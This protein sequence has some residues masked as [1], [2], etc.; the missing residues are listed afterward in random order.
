MPPPR[1]K[2][3]VEGAAGGDTLFFVQGWPDDPTLWDELVDALS[4]RYRCVRVVLPNYEGG[5]YRRW[6]YSHDDIVE[7]LA[8]CIR[9]FAAAKP[10]TLVAHDW[11][12]LWGYMLHHRHPELVA[13]IVG[14]D[15]G[16]DM[17]PSPR[18][19]VLLLA[20]QW[21]L[22]AAFVSGGPIGDWMTRRFARM[23]GTPRQG[24]ALNASINYPYLYTWRDIVT[25]RAAKA[26]RGYEPQVPV[27]FVYGENK[28]GR[29]HSERW[30]ERVRSSPGNQVVGLAG[31]DHW[32]TRDPKLKKLVRDWLDG[33]V[34][35]RTDDSALAT[36]P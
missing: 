10:V 30:L 14:L 7:G 24:D 32:V 20:Y 33:A 21:W 6:G 15:V 26:L 27:L 23:A 8:D 5:E 22:L 25:G 34:S 2:P 16:P 11:G 3:I 36:D 18:E 4:D 31:T 13:R 19:L 28:P 9:S 35:A 17:K 29:F 1:L 12:A